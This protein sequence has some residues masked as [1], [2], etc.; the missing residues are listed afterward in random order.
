MG[1]RKK[2]SRKPAP[3]RKKETL[4]TQFSC[5][6]CHHENSVSVK[7]DRKEGVG[8]LICRVC[9]QRFQARINHLSEAIDVYSDWIDATEAAQNEDQP[10]RR[11]A[12]AA[13]SR[14]ARL[15]DSDDE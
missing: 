6:F 4:A 15:P 3:S 2:S 11:T 13:S 10:T 8:N 12:P 14:A 5:I 1:K 9:D 7:L